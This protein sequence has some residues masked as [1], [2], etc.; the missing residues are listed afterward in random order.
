M[1][2]YDMTGVKA[3]L[4]RVDKRFPNG[5]ILE[6]TCNP[7]NRFGCFGTSGIAAGQDISDKRDGYLSSGRPDG[8][9]S[10]C[11]GEAGWGACGGHRPF[12]GLLSSSQTR[13]ACGPVGGRVSNTYGKVAP[14]KYVNASEQG[15]GEHGWGTGHSAD[16][17]SDVGGSRHKPCSQASRADGSYCRVR[18]SPD[19]AYG[20]RGVLCAPIGVSACGC[21]L[22][23][24]ICFNQ[25]GDCE[26]AMLQPGAYAGE[27]MHWTWCSRSWSG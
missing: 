24:I 18:A 15:Y 4:S 1:H 13:S 21:E 23:G 25:F 11:L 12:R 3:R 16:G 22:L 17:S 6:P 7:G 2:H 20:C 10:H 19:D 26:G 14:D 5:C 9:L 27:I 8:G